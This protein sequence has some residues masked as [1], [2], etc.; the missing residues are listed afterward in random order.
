[1]TTVADGTEM[2][3][4]ALWWVRPRVAQAMRAWRSG[5]SPE[6]GGGIMDEQ[7]NGGEWNGD[8]ERAP[9]GDEFAGGDES[10]GGDEFTG[11][12]E[13]AAGDEV[14]EGAPDA[15]GELGQ[16]ALGATSGRRRTRFIIDFVGQVPARGNLRGWRKLASDA[17]TVGQYQ[18]VRERTVADGRIRVVRAIAKAAD[19]NALFKYSLDHARPGDEIVVSPVVGLINAITLPV[20]LIAELQASGSDPFNPLGN[21]SGTYTFSYV[22]PARKRL[23]VKFKQPAPPAPGAARERFLDELLNRYGLADGVETPLKPAAE[24]PAPRPREGE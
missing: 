23:E 12:D 14:I 10:T 11:G 15:G 7:A 19:P 17:E 4:V 3:S 20:A 18:L 8:D 22:V 21:G 24:D 13:L 5:P 1:M 9:S 16:S 2:T 6:K